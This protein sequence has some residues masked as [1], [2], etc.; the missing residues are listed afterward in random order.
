MNLATFTTIVHVIAGSIALAS[1]WAAALARKGSRPHVLAGRI[2]L[3]AMIAIILS[4]IPLVA[5]FAIEGAWVFAAFFGYLLLLVSFTC[6]TAWRAV[7][8]RSHP[9]RYTGP[10][11]WLLLVLVACSGAGIG[12]LGLARGSAILAAF[13]AIGPLAGLGGL[14]IRRRIRTDRLW[15]LREHFG[16]MIGN[17]VATHVAFMSIGLRTLVPHADP[18]LLTYLAW[19][20]P[21]S[22]ALVAGWWLNRRYGPRAARTQPGS[23]T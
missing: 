16:A 19:F 9:E 14:R 8:D 4:G 10:M 7:R 1:F 18:V 23:A 11:Y 17:G 6:W 5:R 2:Y 15:W 3:I 13:G 22:A 21:L 20:G 12:V